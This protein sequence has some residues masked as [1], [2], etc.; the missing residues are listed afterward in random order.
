MRRPGIRADLV[1]APA[2]ISSRLRIH[3]QNDEIRE[4]ALA[5]TPR[6]TETSNPSAHDDDGKF[7][8]ALRRG[9]RS[10]VAQH[11]AHLKRIVDERARDGPVRLERESNEGGASAPEKFAPS[12]LQ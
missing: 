3:F 6:G 5:Q 11:V 2:R 7:L 8:D 1:L 10:V 12:N 4:A 9:K